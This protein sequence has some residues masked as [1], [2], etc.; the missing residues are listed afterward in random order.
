MEILAHLQKNMELL[1][2]RMTLMTL[3]GQKNHILITGMTYCPNFHINAIVFNLLIE[4]NIFYN[5]AICKD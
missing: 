1:E 2:F 3:A 4:K 5:S